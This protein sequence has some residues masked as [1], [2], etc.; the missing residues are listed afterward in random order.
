M[1]SATVTRTQRPSVRSPIERR[2]SGSLPPRVTRPQH[3]GSVDDSM[4]APTKPQS[5]RATGG[6]ARSATVLTTSLSVPP[7]GQG[8]FTAAPPPDSAV[9][10]PV[11]PTSGRQT[12]KMGFLTRQ[13]QHLKG[14]K[15]RFYVLRDK[16][17]FYWTEQPTDLAEAFAAPYGVI[18]LENCSVL[19]V[20]TREEPFT[21]LISH[22]QFVSCLRFFVTVCTGVRQSTICEHKTAMT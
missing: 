19:P 8:V 1:E 18:F 22:R 14:W 17:L 21:F 9:S 2:G 5:S 3:V 7:E 20:A 11:A 6:L 13:G 4:T 10:L 15:P 16:F 12:Y